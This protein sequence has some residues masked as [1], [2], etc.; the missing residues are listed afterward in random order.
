MRIQVD[1]P[2]A[3]GVT[4]KDVVLHLIGLI[5]T[6]GGTGAVIEFCGTTFEQMSMEGRMSVA[7]MAIEGGARA[8]MIAPD[9]ITFKYLEGRPL[10]PAKGPEWDAA[11]AYWKVCLLSL[12]KGL[13]EES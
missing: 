10:A 1:G 11:V 4:A 2:L 5:G 9:E 8:G 6:A 12:P 3:D 13:R 7:N